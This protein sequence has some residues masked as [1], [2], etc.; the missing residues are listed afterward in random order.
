M[1]LTDRT[2][3][4]RPHLAGFALA[5]VMALAACAEP[6]QKLG[7]CEEGVGGLS[8]ATTLVPANC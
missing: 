2:G 8:A 7:E 5:L 1:R 3:D 4:R 6:E